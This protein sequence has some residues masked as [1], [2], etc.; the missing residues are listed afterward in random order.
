MTGKQ[1]GFSILQMAV[2]T[3]TGIV[4]TGLGAYVT[5]GRDVVHTS[6]MPEAVARYSP[7]L[8]D[9]ASIQRQLDQ[10]DRQ[11]DHNSNELL[12]LRDYVRSLDTQL[13]L[14]RKDLDTALSVQSAGPEHPNGY[15]PSPG[16]GR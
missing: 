15:I 13:A 6:D 14:L 9:R 10:I 11:A 8:P 12:Y 4:A 2:V 5:L 1:D 16:G 3:L 7:Y